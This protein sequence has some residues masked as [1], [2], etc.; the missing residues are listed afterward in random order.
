[1]ASKWNF[2]IRRRQRLVLTLG[3][4][5]LVSLIA[6]FFSRF[7]N[8]SGI[9]DRKSLLV[10]ELNRDR[11]SSRWN[12]G[13]AENYTNPLS[14]NAYLPIAFYNDTDPLW[15]SSKAETIKNPTQ[16]W[17]HIRKV[18]EAHLIRNRDRFGDEPLL[19]II[20]IQ[21]HNRSTHLMYLIESLR[22]VRYIEKALV[23]FSHDFFSPE[24]NR[25]L[26]AIRFVRFTQ[27][28]FPYSK[29]LFPNSY[30]GPHIKDCHNKGYYLLILILYSLK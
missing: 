14:S 26:E 22:K 24:T 7:V 18:N 25:M 27:I 6:F 5:S 10:I 3:Y 16:L 30:P 17:K 1:M 2:Y 9:F 11:I 23:V 4:L 29:Q 21:V 28:F 15:S 12:Y 8:Y 20:I 19:F 13:V